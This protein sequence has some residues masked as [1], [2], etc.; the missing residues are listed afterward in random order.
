MT[1][2]NT[3]RN[4]TASLVMAA[5]VAGCGGGDGGGSPADGGTSL[6]Q[7]ALCLG[8]LIWVNGECVESSD[9]PASAAPFPITNDSSADAGPPADNKD[10]WTLTYVVEVEPNDTMDMAQPARVATRTEQDEYVGFFAR[11][12]LNDQGDVTDVYVFTAE[13]SRDYRFNLRTP[14]GGAPLDVYAAFFR[15][16]DQGGN[17][18]LTTQANELSQNHA[19]MPIDAGLPYYVELVAGDTVGADLDY[20]LSVAE[21]AD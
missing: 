4:L 8:L 20:R 16:R 7:V 13:V 11:G 3:I 5:M 15:V 10:T 14:D 1:I 18:L 12:M 9:E 19:I 21:V 6:A 17:V 2:R